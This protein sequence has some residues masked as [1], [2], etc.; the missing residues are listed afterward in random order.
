MKFGIR[1]TLIILSIIMIISELIYGI[2]FLGGSIIVSF[3]WQPLLI[4]AAIYFIMVVMLAFDNQNS[5]LPMLLIPL[6]GIVG[7]LVA[8]IPVVGMVTHWILF[9]LMILFLIVVLSTPIYIP[10]K[11][12]RI[13]YDEKGRRIK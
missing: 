1:T 6:I 7:S 2:P 12:A 9:F 4:N 5:I 11:N 10:D 3:G 13:T 8:I